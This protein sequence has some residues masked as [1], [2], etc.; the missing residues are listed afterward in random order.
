MILLGRENP[1][2][3]IRLPDE[4]LRRPARWCCFRLSS[5]PR[6]RLVE[7]RATAVER[8]R[9]RRVDL[10]PTPP[11]S[12]SKSLGGIDCIGL[13]VSC[14]VEDVI[15]LELLL[16]ICCRRT[17]E[18]GDVKGRCHGIWIRDNS[19]I[20]PGREDIPSVWGIVTTHNF[21]GVL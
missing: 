16:H 13:S 1:Q 14:I 11:Q 20:T 5:K 3:G 4:S 15:Y 8:Y 7:R 10:A 21:C 9:L 18:M 19:S 6:D 2:L 17:R 12:H